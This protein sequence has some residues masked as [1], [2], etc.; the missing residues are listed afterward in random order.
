MIIPSGKIISGDSSLE[1]N[2]QLDMSTDQLSALYNS[3]H[4]SVAE[5]DVPA[6]AISFITTLPEVLTVDNFG[7]VDGV[8]ERDG[9]GVGDGDTTGVG[10]VTLVTGVFVINGVGDTCVFV[11]S[12]DG[13]T[14]VSSLSELSTAPSLPPLIPINPNILENQFGFS[15]CFLAYSVFV[16]SASVINRF[17]A[18]AP[19]KTISRDNLSQ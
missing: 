13:V 17:N 16:F 18:P 4:S 1:T 7:V 10:V 11:T 15:G 14:I 12:N 19:F 8:G 2:C 9:F 3:I 6:H 5:A